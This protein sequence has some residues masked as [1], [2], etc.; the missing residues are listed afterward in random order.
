MGRLT[1]HVLDMESGIPAR[2]MRIELHAGASSLGGA[3]T[4]DDGRCA[5][6]ML[7]GEAFRRGEYALS[8]HVGAYFRARGAE[9]PDPPFLDI[10]VIRFGIAVPSTH[11]HV[12]LL[13]SRWGYTTYRGS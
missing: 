4:G 9:L 1:T 2:G 10:V 6:P 5:T 7:E 11:Y 8:F 13:V 3:V 12:P